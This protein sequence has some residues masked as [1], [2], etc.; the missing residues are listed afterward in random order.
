M[1][2]SAIILVGGTEGNLLHQSQTANGDRM[3]GNSERRS[4][5]NNAHEPDHQKATDAGK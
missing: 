5:Y 4:G 2:L 1:G 3:A